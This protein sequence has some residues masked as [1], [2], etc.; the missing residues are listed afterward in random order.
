[1]RAWARFAPRVAR[2]EE[3]SADMRAQLWDRPFVERLPSVW[4]EREREVA[5]EAENFNA[6][7]GIAV[8][9]ALGLTTWA[10]FAFVLTLLFSTF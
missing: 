1:M 9:L 4:I 6:V 3:A 8:G 7:I 5:I 2:G 10:G